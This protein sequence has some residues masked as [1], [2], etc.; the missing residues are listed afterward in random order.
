MAVIALSLGP[1]L[2][3]GY[4]VR[5]LTS[6]FM[7]TVVT[8]SINLMVGFAGYPAFGNVVFFGV[9]A[10]VAGIMAGVAHAPPAVAIPIAG[11]AAAGYALILG[12][13]ILRLKGG[14]FAIATLGINEATRLV[15]NNLE[16]TGGGRGMTMPIVDLPSATI[17]G[18][19]YYYMLAIMVATVATIGI[20]AN[21]PFGFALRALRDEEEAAKVIGVNTTWFKM[22][23][24]AISAFFTALVG[25]GWAYWIAFFEPASAF[26]IMIAVKGFLMMLLG[27]T[28]TVLGPVAGSFF[29]EIL[30]EVIW[31]EFLNVHRLVLGALIVFIIITLPTGLPQLFRR[32]GLAA[33][34]GGAVKEKANR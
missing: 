7:M 11:L 21:R 3:S 25:A 26:D 23:S 10:Y 9:G 13:P 2:L 16:I 6:V 17:Y 29:V 12:Y 31:G 32:R 28:G 27:G 18:A 30:S 4:W 20:L 34:L 22:L 1:L 8:A 24:W 15:V 14:Y 5:V 33:A 19:I